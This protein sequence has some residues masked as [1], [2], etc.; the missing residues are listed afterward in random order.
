MNVSAKCA[1]E[2]MLDVRGLAILSQWP[3]RSIAGTAFHAGCLP[4]VARPGSIC[5]TVVDAVDFA[6]LGD[7]WSYPHQ[8]Y[9]K[10]DRTSMVLPLGF[11]SLVLS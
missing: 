10:R 7:R 8:S 9:L 1:L 11:A 2:R 4:D 5:F 6:V 3:R